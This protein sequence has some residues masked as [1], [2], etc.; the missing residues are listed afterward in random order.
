MFSILFFFLP[1]KTDTLFYHL[2]FFILSLL[3]LGKKGG[4]LVWWRAYS[5]L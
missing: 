2:Y 5:W 1:H 4:D 3:F